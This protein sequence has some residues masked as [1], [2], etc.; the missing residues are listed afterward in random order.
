MSGV[1]HTSAHALLV[2]HDR[3]EQHAQPTA[4]TW[5]AAAGEEAWEA[6]AM[7]QPCLRCQAGNV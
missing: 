1:F 3:T 6:A 2:P 5:A 4:N 7:A